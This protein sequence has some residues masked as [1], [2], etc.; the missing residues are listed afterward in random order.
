MLSGASRGSGLVLRPPGIAHSIGPC[1]LPNPREEVMICRVWRLSLWRLI[2]SVL[3]GLE[4][5]QAPGPRAKGMRHV[6]YTLTVHCTLYT[7]RLSDFVV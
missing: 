5:P 6:V 7:W 3:R 1:P 4:R 2:R